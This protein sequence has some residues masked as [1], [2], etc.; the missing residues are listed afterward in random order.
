MNSPQ[1]SVFGPAY[2]DRVLHVDGPL[3]DPQTGP[4]LDQSLDGTLKFAESRSL[5]IVDPAR[6]TIK[7]ALPTDWPGPTGQINVSRP[8][9][10]GIT[11]SRS[12]RATSWHD[13][14][15]GMGAGYAA[16]LHGELCFASG[17]SDDPRSRAIAGRLAAHG[18]VNHPIVIANH[19]ADWTLLVSS[20][21]VW[22]Q[23]ADRFSRLPRKHRSGRPGRRRGISPVRPPH[24]GVFA[25][26]AR[27][28][29][30]RRSRR[31]NL[32]LRPGHAQHA[33]PRVP[34]FSLREV[35]RH[36]ELQPPRVGNARR[37]RG[38]GLATVDPDRDRRTRRQLG[39]I[40]DDYR[41]GPRLA[42]AGVSPPA[43]APRYESRG[44]ILCGRPA[45]RPAR[46][47]LECR[48]GR[49]RR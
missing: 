16:A 13:D 6:Y 21:D 8:I 12:V 4:P 2:L 24:R 34:G 18:V 23:A 11:G 10:A 1:V 3:V 22:R 35:D 9:R 39:A 14:L 46:R 30:P 48:V 43:A 41:R 25:Q 29:G 49:H 44:R 42:R 17:S 47:R 5:E 27:G 37:P 20:G 31:K 40:H 36:P 28:A 38:G 26:H 45:C 7:I 32:F 33:R 15:G 19:E